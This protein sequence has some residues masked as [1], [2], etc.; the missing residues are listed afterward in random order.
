MNK[1]E[2]VNSV[3]ALN[4]LINED[5]LKKLEIYAEFLLEYNEHTNLTAIKNI[6]DIYCKHFYDSLTISKVIDLNECETLLDFGTG[7]GFP[8][9]VLKI[10]YPNLQVTL[11]DSNNKKTKFLS[12]LCEKLCI[13]DVNIINDRVENL[14]KVY[15]NYFDC[16]TARAV[17][18]MCVLTELAMPL[19]K[20]DKYFVAMKGSNKEEINEAL[21]AVEKMDGIME[22]IATF[23]LYENCGERNIVKIKKVSKTKLDNLRSYDKIIKKAQVKI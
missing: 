13:N 9:M 11:V 1:E 12:A 10:F 23:T 16:V 22:D 2:F 6:E 18:N 19:V 21:Y 4:V 5:K 15:L 3:K 20:N 8:G 7:A 14:W 17:S